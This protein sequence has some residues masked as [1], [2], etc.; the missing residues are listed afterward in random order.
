M[1]ASISIKN[2]RCNM[3]MNVNLVIRLQYGSNIFSSNRINRLIK[4]VE[5][6]VIGPQNCEKSQRRL[7]CDDP[8]GC[9]VVTCT[10]PSGHF[11]WHTKCSEDIK[12]SHQISF[13]PRFLSLAST[14][15]T[16]VSKSQKRKISLLL[17]YRAISKNGVLS[18]C[19]RCIA[20]YFDVVKSLLNIQTFADY[21]ALRRI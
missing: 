9:C 20:V 10:T 1:N 12:Y 21:N 4:N 15:T 17:H 8:F 19:C 2:F 6:N 3:N 16:K 14:L 7:Q 11:S 18:D 5:P 13:V